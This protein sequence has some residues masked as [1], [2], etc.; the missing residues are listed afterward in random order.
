MRLTLST[1]ILI[2]V[3]ILAF[4]NL[5]ATKLVLKGIFQN[6]YAYNSTYKKAITS[7]SH[8]IVINNT[9]EKYEKGDISIRRN[10][11]CL[12]K[13]IYGV[14]SYI[15]NDTLYL[16]LPDNEEID[17]HY[18]ISMPRVASITVQNFKLSIDGIPTKSLEVNA[19]AN[20]DIT[21]NTSTNDSLALINLNAKGGSQIHIIDDENSANKAM[22]HSN[23]SIKEA[24]IKLYENSKLSISRNIE[25]LTIDTDSSSQIAMPSYM[26]LRK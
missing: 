18:E 3:F 6:K 17:F 2:S 5:I 1:K 9:I 13:D 12:I 19:F 11:S 23:L 16:V 7:F 10:D 14:N 21:I 15:L 22:K 20:A 24:N 25:K 8:I 26:L 4:S